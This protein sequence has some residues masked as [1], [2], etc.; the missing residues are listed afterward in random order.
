MAKLHNDGRFCRY[1]R[2][3]LHME[4]TQ[5][6][7]TQQ[8]TGPVSC[9]RAFRT[10]APYWTWAVATCP[11]SSAQCSGADNMQLVRV[12]TY[13]YNSDVRYINFILFIYSFIYSHVYIIIY[14]IYI[15]MCVWIYFIYI[16]RIF[17][18]NRNHRRVY[19]YP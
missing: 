17:D 19:V 16:I 10:F 18:N 11:G 12:K 14:Y 5:P 7:V 4:C 6:L 3:N 2:S 13:D 15:C 1:L 8:T 9:W